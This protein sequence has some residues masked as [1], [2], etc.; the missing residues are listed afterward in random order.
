MVRDQCVK[1]LGVFE[2][3]KDGTPVR[4]NLFYRNN[5]NS[6]VYVHR[7]C[8]EWWVR[9]VGGWLLN[10]GGGITQRKWLAHVSIWLLNL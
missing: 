10:G 6:S 5:R 8:L 4:T 2:N 3:R 7:S 1:R 9:W